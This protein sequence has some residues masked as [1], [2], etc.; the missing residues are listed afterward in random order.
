MLSSSS[1]VF[2]RETIRQYV[3]TFVVL[4]AALFSG[5]VLAAGYSDYS[6]R[7]WQIQDGL[8]Q[9]SVTSIV[10]TPDG[11]LWLATFNGL[12]RFDGA[13]FTVY[14]EA[15][16]PV[17]PSSRL[18]R[19]DA[20]H[21]GGLWIHTEEG[22]LVRYHEGRFRD[23]S[24]LEGFPAAGAREVRRIGNHPL[25]LVD[26]SGGIHQLEGDEW[27]T[28]RQH[29]YLRGTRF[30]YW[31]DPEANLWAWCREKRSF[32]RVMAGRVQWLETPDDKEASVRAYAVSRA[33]G[34][35]LVIS[36]QIWHL[37]YRRNDWKPTSWVLPGAARGLMH[38]LEDKD[39]N[40]WL[41]TYGGGLFRFGS[42]GEIEQFTVESGLSDNAVRALYEDTENNLWVGTDGGGLNCLRR[43]VVRM[44]GVREGLA[45]P[46]VMSVGRDGLDSGAVWLGLNGGGVNRVEDGL[47]RP[48][49]HE[50]SIAAN[51]FVYGLLAEKS[52]ALWIG[53]YDAGVFRLDG[54]EVMKMAVPGQWEGRPMLAALEDQTG[55]IW[56]GGGGDLLRLHDG[57]AVPMNAALGWSNVVVRALA[58]D[59]SG[60][61]YVGTSGHGL[62]RWRGG[63]WTVFSKKDGLA[64]DRITAV[65]VDAE[66]TVWTGAWH[67]GLSRFKQGRF[68]NYSTSDGLP[69]NCIGAIIEDDLGNLWFG[70]NR[71]I[72]R[73]PKQ[74]LNLA[75]DQGRKPLPVNSYGLGDGLSTLECGG[76]AHP[77]VC[78]TPDGSLWFATVR[79]VAV[80]NPLQLAVNPIPPPVIIEEV[81][82]DDQLNALAGRLEGKTFAVPP[83]KAR[84]ELRFTG[85]SF[86][87][88]EKVRFRYR[89]HGLD[90]NWVDAGANRSA[91]YAHLPHGRYRFEVIACNND[92]VWS[93]PG[94]SLGIAILP[95][96]W[97]TW[98]FRMLGALCVSGI[99]GWLLFLH[100][101]RLQRERSI[102]T[103]FARRLIHSQEKER[104]RIAA[105]LHDSLGQN[106]L[107][108]KNRALLGIRGIQTHSSQVEQLEEISRVASQS[109]EEVREIS[110]NLRPFQIDRLGLTKAVEVMLENVSEASGLNLT[111]EIEPV[112]GLL[113]PDSEIH[114]YRVIQELLNN[115]V[116]HSDASL[117]RVHLKPAA[118]FIRLTVGDDGRGFDYDLVF[119]RPAE[120]GS[121][122]RDVSERVRIL[123]GNLKCHT[124]PGAGTTWQIE[125]PA[126][127]VA[128]E[129]S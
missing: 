43:R 53:T 20:D 67:G 40:V 102:E 68:F 90:A 15:S 63:E 18:V 103:A 84:V 3:L 111:R 73:I 105:E 126:T 32:G 38:M 49:I 13:R 35:W 100:W 70:S 27:I 51:S 124:R 115:V 127:K 11:Y 104:R 37:N 8:P 128:D 26:R 91:S 114:V 64:S 46:V 83:G 42:S 121:G 66:D 88:P 45:A 47:I 21:E 69:S 87:A 14:D 17:F 52:G 95:P 99:L 19:L 81:I 34:L 36:N 118:S 125:I 82:V 30:S 120:Q 48:S 89:L 119:N 65:F 60:N 56:L 31:T 2:R 92:G 71:G 86:A 57:Q 93:D 24:L 116:K 113:S 106:L 78:K 79:G 22:G 97:M 4:R 23:F 44:L 50:G 75:A 25:F 10:Q 101:R 7:S 77:A 109:I 117:I 29:E 85:L 123:G 80:V 61:I 98:W 112:N 72:F 39:G 9:N 110:Q 16:A 55:A 74:Q 96:W 76:G 12:A 1:F 122:L 5:G 41:A 62:L 94:A 129:R 59:R 108:I 33:G 54:R 28:E 6:I 107:V 58:E